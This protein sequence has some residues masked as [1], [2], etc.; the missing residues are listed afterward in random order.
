VLPLFVAAFLAAIAVAST[1]L[2]PAP[3]LRIAATVQ[4]VLLVAALAG[5]GTGIKLTLLRRTG[6]PALALGVAS[7]VLVAAVAYAGVQLVHP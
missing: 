3:A 5:L 6:G 2:V 4:N 7:W 1:G